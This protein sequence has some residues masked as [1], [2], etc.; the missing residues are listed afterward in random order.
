MAR[1]LLIASL[2]GCRG[3]AGMHAA[4]AE[5]CKV[6]VLF[7]AAADNSNDSR[8]TA[9]AVYAEYKFDN[10]VP[11]YASTIVDSSGN[12]RNLQTQGS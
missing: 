1:V 3:A 9:G 5:S 12:G 11:G 6:P 4:P 2:V 8:Q 10:G 7:G